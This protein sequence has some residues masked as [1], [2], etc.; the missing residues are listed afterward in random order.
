MCVCVCIS[1]VSQ[2]FEIAF[3][4]SLAETSSMCACVCARAC[5]YTDVFFRVRARRTFPETSHREERQISNCLVFFPTTTFYCLWELMVYTLNPNPRHQ[6]SV[7][8]Q[9]IIEQRIPPSKTSH[10]HHH[11]PQFEKSLEDD[12]R[13][14]SPR[15]DVINRRA[16]TTS[17]GARRCC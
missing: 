17:I 15:E 8:A 7:F 6:L 10:Q 11:R 5:V 16:T 3:S 13:N 2:L 4:T 12:E 14:F 9:K 1:P